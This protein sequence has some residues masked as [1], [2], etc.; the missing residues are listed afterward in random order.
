MLISKDIQSEL[1]SQN[2]MPY[3]NLCQYEHIA[4]F[5][6]W[7]SFKETQKNNRKKQQI[8]I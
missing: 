5:V 8:K 1:G 3:A 4:L 7:G 6:K 2:K